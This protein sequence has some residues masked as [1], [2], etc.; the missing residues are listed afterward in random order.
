MDDSSQPY[1][2]A[3]HVLEHMIDPIEAL[4][5]WHRLLAPGGSLLI[6]LPD[7]A[8]ENTLVLDYTHVH[9][10]TTSSLDNLVKAVGFEVISIEQG[11]FNTIR[12]ICKKPEGALV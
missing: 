3:A 7:H 2:I 4:E 12:A 1:I 10:Y 5:E 6:T 11:A 9:A 8:M